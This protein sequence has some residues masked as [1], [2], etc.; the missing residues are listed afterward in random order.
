MARHRSRLEQLVFRRRRLCRR[1]LC[2]LWCRARTRNTKESFKLKIKNTRKERKKERKQRANV[3]L[4]PSSSR[5]LREEID[6]LD[7]TAVFLSRARL[8]RSLLARIL[9]ARATD[10]AASIFFFLIFSRASIFFSSFE[11]NE[12]ALF[13]PPCVR[14]RLRLRL[15]RLCVSCVVIH[16]EKE[17]EDCEKNA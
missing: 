13:S 10:A 4:F 17:K 6:F 8:A 5:S 1:R 9:D 15:R 11:V 2:R 16:G 7:E 14:L 3:P 12:K